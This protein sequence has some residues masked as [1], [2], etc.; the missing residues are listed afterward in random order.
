MK[1]ISHRGNINGPATELE[2]TP[3]YIDKAIENGY[4][5]EID[6][7]TYN[8]ALFLGHDHADHPVEEKWL[9]ERKEKLWV[10][11]KDFSSLSSLI[12][13][14]LRIF[15]H[16]KEDYTIISNGLIWA[17]KL[18][19]INSRCIIPLISLS[20]IQKKPEIK[21]WGACSDYVER[22]RNAQ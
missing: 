12:D 21:V 22:L 1:L 14:E 5:V 16:E 13:T 6:I 3:D 4:D 18:T 9:L 7:R 8:G 11:C 10:H 15:Y 20:D 19:E 2:N 17:H